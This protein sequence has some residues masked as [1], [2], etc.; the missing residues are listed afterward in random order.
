VIIFWIDKFDYTVAWEN[1]D[2]KKRNL[3]VEIITSFL[4]N[5]S[6]IPYDISPVNLEHF[7][8]QANIIEIETVRFFF[9]RVAISEKHLEIIEKNA[10]PI[11][12]PYETDTI[13]MQS[14]NEPATDVESEKSENCSSDGVSQSQKQSAISQV[15]R[16]ELLNKLR[17]E[18]KSR[19]L[20]DCTLR[21]YKGAVS[22]FMDW[23]TPELAANWSTAFKKYL[24][25]LREERKLAPKTVQWKQYE[26]LDT[27]R[28]R[29]IVTTQ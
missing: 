21:H 1:I 9:E 19:N 20:A 14:Q 3:M 10:P 4:Q 26:V 6:G 12:E 2:V 16:I 18:I 24:V 22:R 15:E 29:T 8:K 11:C 13:K 7:I 5:N 25:W 17:L 23:L 28:L 27:L